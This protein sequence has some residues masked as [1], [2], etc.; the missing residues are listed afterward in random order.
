MSTATH[1]LLAAT[2]LSVAS[3]G[4][5]SY[6]VAAEPLKAAFVYI[7]PPGDHGW[8]Y[9]HDQARIR[10]EKDLKGL[11]KTSFVAN[12]PETGDAERV[13]RNLAQQGNQVIFGTSFGYMNAMEKVAKTYPN[14]VF[15]HAT[16]YKSSKIW[17]I[18][19]SAP[20]KGHIYWVYWQVNKVKQAK[21]G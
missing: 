10:T 7:G 11:V 13:F 17:G 1:G 19:I 18:I 15:M 14:T 6:A 21:L 16:G 4:I 5:T 2:A 12:V 20:I 8:T 9:A 3:V